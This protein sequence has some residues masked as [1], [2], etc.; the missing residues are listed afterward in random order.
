MSTYDELTKELTRLYPQHKEFLQVVRKLDLKLLDEYC[1]QGYKDECKP[2]YCE[3]RILKSCRF[4]SEY[5]KVQDQLNQKGIFI[6]CS[7]KKHP[8]DV[9]SSTNNT[10]QPKQK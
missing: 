4:W 9:I 3:Y 5:E 1:N 10:E 6:E 8:S 7:F 2:A